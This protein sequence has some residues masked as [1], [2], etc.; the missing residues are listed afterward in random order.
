MEPD[1]GGRHRLRLADDDRELLGAAVGGPE[2]DDARVLGVGERHPGLA[3]GPQA[4]RLELAV[5]ADRVEQHHD[6]RGVDGGRQADGRRQQAGELAQLDGPRRE[7]VGRDRA[8]RQRAGVGIGGCGRIGERGDELRRDLGAE[9]DLP[10][11]R[12]LGR[13]AEAGQALVGEDQD[14]AGGPGL[15][16][17]AGRLRRQDP[18]LAAGCPDRDGLA[19]PE[20]ARGVLHEEG[21]RA[22]QRDGG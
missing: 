13:L 22:R 12:P 21:G 10:R 18:D 17:P 6:L 14:R 4:Q 20:G 11:G 15:D 9:R 19:G 16:G 7:L 8:P 2:G 3:D 1:E 5:V